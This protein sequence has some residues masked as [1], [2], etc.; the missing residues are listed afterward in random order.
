MRR[1]VVALGALLSGC[2][3]AGPPQYMTDAARG[4]ADARRALVHIGYELGPDFETRVVDE[5]FFLASNG[6]MK[7]L[8]TAELTVRKMMDELYRQYLSR[9]ASRPVRIYC[10]RDKSSYD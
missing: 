4:E 2:I 7:S 8:E 10:F 5:I 1:L 3:N 6:G 9:R